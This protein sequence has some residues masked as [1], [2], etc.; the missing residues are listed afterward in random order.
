MITFDSTHTGAHTH[1]RAHTHMFTACVQFYASTVYHHY[2]FQKSLS[3][4]LSIDRASLIL[5]FFHGKSLG[6]HPECMQL[7]FLATEGQEI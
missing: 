7:T 4:T 3:N 2:A 1:R 5:V 6:M